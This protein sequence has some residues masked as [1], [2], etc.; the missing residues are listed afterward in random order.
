MEEQEAMQQAAVD[1]DNAARPYW[2]DSRYGA[3]RGLGYPDL[4]GLETE[5]LLRD[6]WVCIDL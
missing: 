2:C 5:D 6:D 3:M 1:L 4:W